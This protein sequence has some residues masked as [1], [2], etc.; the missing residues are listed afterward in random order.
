MTAAPRRPPADQLVAPDGVA[1]A[2]VPLEQIAT[3]PENYNEH[4]RL[5]LDALKED[6]KRFGQIKPYV[7]KQQGEGHYLL[8][9]GEGCL[10]AVQEL[11]AEDARR[12]AHLRTAKIVIVPHWWTDVD[13]EGYMTADNE[14]GRL[15]FPDEARLIDLL[16][17]QQEAGHS[18]LSVGHDEVSFADLLAKYEP[19]DLDALAARY[20]D[21]LPEDAF[22]PVIRVKVTPATR[23]RYQALL[24][25]ADGADEGEKFAWILAQVDS[26]DESGDDAP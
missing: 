10:T 5:Q 19:A 21:D 13:I 3:N 9:A 26:S 4:P 23:D 6:F 17:R 7:V 20:G 16:R 24:K 2:L 11:L 15:S 1:Y 14:T 18:L 25:R 12:F 8:A 22:W